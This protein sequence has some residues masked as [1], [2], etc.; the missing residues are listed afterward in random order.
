MP[1]CLDSMY[2]QDGN[3]PETSTT[4][5]GSFS[6]NHRIAGEIRTKK[7]EDK[8]KLRTKKRSAHYF[9]N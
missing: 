6:Q 1:W 4:E 8:Y 5:R 2:R 3:A 9:I 7:I